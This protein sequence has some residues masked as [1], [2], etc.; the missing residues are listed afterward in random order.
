MPKGEDLFK[1]Q[2]DAF[3]GGGGGSF[4]DSPS[5][6]IPMIEKVF[7]EVLGRKPSSRELAYYKYGILKENE[8]RVKLL[9]SMNTKN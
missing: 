6:K 2:N 3:G 9:K 7:K 1:E 5:D 4:S 8:I